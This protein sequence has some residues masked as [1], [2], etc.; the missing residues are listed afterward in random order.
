M[1]QVIIE[2]TGSDPVLMPCTHFFFPKGL[3]AQ[4]FFK[5]SQKKR[6][7]TIILLLQQR[8]LKC[9]GLAIYEPLSNLHGKQILERQ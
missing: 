2:F 1:N 5:G 7:N 9:T 6:H 3:F 8:I 4:T